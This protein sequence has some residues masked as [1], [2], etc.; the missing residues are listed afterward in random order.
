MQELNAREEELYGWEKQ[1]VEE[2]KKVVKRI[3]IEGQRDRERE[4]ER[5]TMMGI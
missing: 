5:V 4:R 1:L 2:E 3:G